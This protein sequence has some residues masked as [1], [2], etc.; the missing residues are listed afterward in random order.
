M[1]TKIRGITIELTGDTKGLVKSFDN[2]RKATNKVQTQLRDINKALK[3]DPKNTEVLKQKQEALGKQVSQTDKYLQEQKKLLE[4]MQKADN[5]S[6]T[7]ETQK[8]LQREIAETEQKLKSAKEELRNFGSVGAQQVAV[9]GEQMKELGGKVSDVGAELTKKVTVPIVA[10][11]T[12]STKAF[13][14]WES[15]FTGVMKTVDETATTTYEDI[16]EGLKDIATSTA[17]SKEEIAGVAEVAGQLGISADNVVEFT[18]VMV[19]LGDTTNLSAEEAATSLARVLNITGDS[20]DSIEQLGSVIVD[21]GNNF[22]TSESEIVALTNRMAASGKL[23]GLTTP[24]IMALAASMSSVGIQAEAG[25]TAMTQ[26]LTALESEV[27][28]F[29]AGYESNLETIGSIAN[30]SAE[31]FANAWENEPIVA[32]QSFIAGLGELDEKGES[33]TLI[34]DEL[35]MSGVRQSNMLKSLALASETVGNAMD[36]ANGAYA[37]NTALQNEAAK[38]Y[39][40]T[41]AK[42]SQMKERISEV[43]ISIGEILIPYVEKVIDFIERMTEKWNSL[44]PEMQSTIVHIGLVVAAIGPLLLT[45]GKLI[46]GI[47]QIL[48]FA[49]A[50]VGAIGTIGGIVTGTLIPAI[51]SFL[52][53]T[54]PIAI[55]IGVIVAAG[56][57]LYKNWETISAKAIEIW[58]AIKE[59]FTTTLDAIKQKFTEIWNSIKLAVFLVWTGIQV[60]ATTVWN[61]I[62]TTIANVVDGIKTKVTNVFNAVKTTVTNVFESLKST[63]SRIWEGI[64]SAITNPIETAKTLVTNAINTIK[65]LFP[66]SMGKIFSGIKL[67]HFTISGGEAPW[68]IG[69]KGTRPSVDIEWYAKAA[70]SGAIF[71]REALFG[72]S[73]GKFLGAGDA[74]QP[75][76]LIGTNTLSNMI[77]SAVARGMSSDAIY[78]AVLRGTS[79]ARVSVYIDGKDVTGIVNKY[80]T[81]N[82]LNRLRAQ[83]I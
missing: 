2:V 74:S 5:A 35:G 79:N 53:A 18:R 23:A 9:V 61:T 29:T 47:G 34:L 83:G 30:M 64:K 81:S 37:N 21:L 63:V 22:A 80:N 39:E 10:A 69:G 44:S 49:P 45:A 27:A 20:T 25:G 17:S 71:S 54:A 13:I 24:E 33:A 82:Q 78:E 36:V 67:P 77:A 56:V 12:A 8:A 48:T 1:A 40:T 58:G 57:L 70:E 19:M 3:V 26:T 6:E 76:L 50:I 28:N 55:A 72:F 14:D 46:I 68:G 42:L 51:A 7:I 31:E 32:I 66:I 62:K 4:E 16:A 41:A 15:A 59:W 38:R 65:G 73:N 60:V 52:A 11:Y 75:E 43:A